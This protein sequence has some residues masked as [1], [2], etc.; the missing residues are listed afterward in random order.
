MV[1][2]GKVGDRE[3]SHLW[4]T[5]MLGINFYPEKLDR[6]VLWAFFPNVVAFFTLSV[7]GVGEYVQNG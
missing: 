4:I 1:M 2:T 3:L 6:S 7:Y 5:F